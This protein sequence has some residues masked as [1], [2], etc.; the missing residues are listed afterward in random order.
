MKKR[1]ISILL[2]LAMVLLMIPTTVFAANNYAPALS[3]S[4][5]RT[6]STI[7]ATVKAAP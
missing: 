1:I 6:G 5:E 2:V 7:I 3:V 4:A